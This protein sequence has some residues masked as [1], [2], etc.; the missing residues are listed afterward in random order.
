VREAL[1]VEG[2]IL[3]ISK[4]VMPFVDRRFENFNELMSYTFS[5]YDTLLC[6]MATGIVVRAI[7]GFLKSKTTDPAILVMDEAGDYCI[8]LLS[9][10]LGGGNDMARLVEKHTSAKAVITTASDVKGKLAVDTLAQKLGLAIDDMGSAKDITAM[11]VNGDRV[12][13][14]GKNVDNLPDYL[15]QDE[16]VNVDKYDGV[17]YISNSNKAY[18]VKPYVQLVPRNIIIGIGCRRGTSGE[19]IIH[20]VERLLKELGIHIKAVA[21]VATVDIK[22]DEAGITKIAEHIDSELVIIDRS[23]IAEVESLFACSDFVKKTIGVGCVAEPC[24]YITS[25]MG[26]KLCDVKKID[27]M[28]ISVWEDKSWGN[29]TL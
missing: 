2:D 5:S 10:H 8:S 6:V 14:C 26:K 23:E 4:R 1:K 13:I 27:C 18:I 28:T 11:I 20:N 16:L 17:I 15:V 29:Y 9:G 22:K 21:K 7:S 19:L 12:M 3:T 25:N 24:G